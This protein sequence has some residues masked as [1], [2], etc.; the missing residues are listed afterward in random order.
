MFGVR[1]A[2]QKRCLLSS[3]STL[4]TAEGKS[5]S[6]SSAFLLNLCQV[7]KEYHYKMLIF[8][9]LNE[10]Q[11]KNDTVQDFFITLNPEL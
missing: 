10:D 1:Y 11:D 8:V 2:A 3:Q 6:S 4:L 5:S 7:E 9:H